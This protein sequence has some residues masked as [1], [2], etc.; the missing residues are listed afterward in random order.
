[1]AL[2]LLPPT[3]SSENSLALLS[4]IL[5]VD[6]TLQDT[7][8]LRSKL[9]GDD[10]SWQV[11][12]DFAGAHGMLAALVFELKQRSLL[13]PLPR[14]IH[15]ANI[16]GHVSSR[17]EAAYAQHLARRN[18]LREQ[19]SEVLAALN[20]RKIVPLLIKGAR[21]LTDGCAQ[22][23][24]AR[25]MRDLD[26]LVRREDADSAIEALRAIGYACG[27]DP[28]PADHHL[29]EMRKPG[30]HFPVEL[31]TQALSFAG[32]K[33]LATEHVWAVSDTGR[34][35]GHAFRVLPDEWQLLHAL[36]HHQVSDRGYARHILAIKDL[37]EFAKLGHA[38]PQENWRSIAAHME[39]GGGSEFLGSWIVQ[40]GRLFGLAPPAGVAISANARDHAEATMRQA[41]SPY[42]LRRALFVADKLR[43]AFSGATLAVRYRLGEGD[44]GAPAMAKHI[45]FLFRLHRGNALRRMIG[46]RD[47]MS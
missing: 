15:G 16:D 20:L 25:G 21:Y 34:L 40:A 27:N 8:A 28:S 36:L 24:E 2:E 13:L 42:W 38:L 5:R 6:Y 1:L 41:R 37:W 23:C 30:R 11:L 33:L 22:W 46:R 7:S 12:V 14:A 32:R 44:S 29:P 31:H 45:G 10:F 17:L 9:F 26:I 18:E 19:L 39:G 4:E 3:I 35:A 47:R 43:F